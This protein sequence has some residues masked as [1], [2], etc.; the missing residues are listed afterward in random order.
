[1]SLDYDERR[2]LLEST[3][4]H[5]PPTFAS[6]IVLLSGLL[7]VDLAIMAFYTVRLYQKPTDNQL[8]R[9]SSNDQNGRH[10][11]DTANNNAMEPSKTDKNVT[12]D[13]KYSKG[14]ATSRLQYPYTSNLNQNTMRRKSY[15]K[16]QV[17][18]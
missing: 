11:L 10:Q 6:S 1:M 15:R 17:L 9:K 2:S 13:K 12:L 16:T 5:S 8:K 3:T 4:N 7:L 18:L 14:N